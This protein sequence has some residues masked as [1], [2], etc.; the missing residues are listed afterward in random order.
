VRRTLE[1]IT[2]LTA[3]LGS[4]LSPLD[5]LDARVA[6]LVPTRHLQERQAHQHVPTV[7]R[8][9]TR[10]AR[11]ARALHAHL[12][13]LLLADR[14]LVKTWARLHRHL[15]QAALAVSTTLAA[16]TVPNVPLGSTSLLQTTLALRA[17]AAAV[18]IT[19]LLQGP[20]VAARV[21]PAAARPTPACR[22]VGFALLASTNRPPGQRPAR[23]AQVGNRPRQ[24][25]QRAKRL[26]VRQVNIKT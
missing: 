21:L 22:P 8:G 20:P 11:Q 4:T 17:R 6:L 25:R 7:V 9:T 26:A 12:V 23:T 18:G 13:N 5:Q 3:S 1:S 10:G 16:L 15:L 24:A 19:R 14:V 2:V